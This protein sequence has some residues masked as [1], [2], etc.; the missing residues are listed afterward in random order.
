[1]PTPHLVHHQDLTNLSRQILVAAGASPAN[2]DAITQHLVDANLCGHDSHGVIRLAEYIADIDLANLNPAVD[3]VVH[4]RSAS[5]ATVDG[6][7]G[8]GQVAANSAVTTGVAMTETT[9]VAVVGVTRCHHLGRLGAYAEHAAATGRILICTAGGHAPI[10][11]VHGGRGRSLG[12]NPIGTGFPT[13]TLPFVMDF[14]TTAVAAG[15]VNV[16]A[17]RGARLPTAAIISATGE[18]S[19][20]PDDFLHGGALLPFGEHKGSALAIAAELLTSA[21]VSPPPDDDAP[22]TA[23]A[24]QAAL[25]VFIRSDIFNAAPSVAERAD[26]IIQTVTDAT[27]RADAPVLSPGQPEHNTLQERSRH[28]VPIEPATL[29]TLRS[30]AQRFDIRPDAVDAQK[31]AR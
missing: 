8:F 30:L 26:R 4:Q 7:W 22:P 14:A 21:L 15:K 6:Q 3:P 12:A 17:A 31:T 29:G 27:P 25:F 2:A 18:L 16:A 9:P 19:D 11:A 23:F 28:G 24:R 20:N 13:S 1:M 10:A 5:T